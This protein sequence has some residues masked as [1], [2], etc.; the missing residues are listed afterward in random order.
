MTKTVLAKHK[1]IDTKVAEVTKTA[2]EKRY[3]SKQLVLIYFM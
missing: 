1:D 3:F 2:L